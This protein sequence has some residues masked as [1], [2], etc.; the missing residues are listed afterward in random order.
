M[1][2]CPGCPLHSSPIWMRDMNKMTC[3]LLTGKGVRGYT[4][5]PGPHKIL[6]MASF[7]WFLVLLCKSSCMPKL[8]A[9]TKVPAM[10]P[11]PYPRHS[12]LPCCTS[13]TWASE[14][15]RLG[16][17]FQVLLSHRQVAQPVWDWVSSFIQCEQTMK[18]WGL[19]VIL[20]DVPNT[21]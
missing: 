19:Y 11:A 6:Q 20:Y 16:S 14:S 21:L 7:R 4:H 2:F 15:D 18:C 10:P 1:L 3:K 9:R 8:I 17:E 13:L 12:L 5:S